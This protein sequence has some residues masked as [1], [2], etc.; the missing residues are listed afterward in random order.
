MEARPQSFT[1]LFLY[2]YG[3]LQDTN[4]DITVGLEYFINGV[5]QISKVR[6]NYKTNL[7]NFCFKMMNTTDV[8][9]LKEVLIKIEQYKNSELEILKEVILDRLSVLEDTYN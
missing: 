8:V 3:T 9:Y 6:K 4:L 2:A 7:R 5:N 1:P